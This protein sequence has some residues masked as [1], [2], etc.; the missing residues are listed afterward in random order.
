[1]KPVTQEKDKQICVRAKLQ[2]PSL[3]DSSSA[4]TPLSSVL[5]PFLGQ[6]LTF[7]L[8]L[9]DDIFRAGNSGESVLD[10]PDDPDL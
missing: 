1:M 6:T 3:P 10:D 7:E 9:L 2:F 5:T 4:V 8:L